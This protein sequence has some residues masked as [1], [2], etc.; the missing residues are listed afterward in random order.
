MLSHIEENKT[1]LDR[2]SDEAT[3]HVCENSQQAQMLCMG[4]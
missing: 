3:F 2:L 1:Y 4:K